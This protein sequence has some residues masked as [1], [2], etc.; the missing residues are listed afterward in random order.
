MANAALKT[1]S[2][3]AFTTTYTPRGT[4][5]EVTLPGINAFS[6]D[7]LGLPAN[8]TA[9]KAPETEHQ[10]VFRLIDERRIEEA[11]HVAK[12]LID[13]GAVEG[14]FI[15]GGTP[16]YRRANI[17]VTDKVLMSRKGAFSD[18]LQITPEVAQRILQHNPENRKIVKAGLVDRIRDIIEGRYELNG[19]T[20]ILTRQGELNDGQHRLWATLL[21]GSTI[22]T[23]VFFGAERD[24]RLTIDTGKVR[25]GETRFSFLGIPNA[26][27]AEALVRLA[28]RVD[29]N[30]EATATE[31]VDTYLLDSAGAGHYQAA[32]KVV[33][34]QPK[35]APRAAMCVAAFMLLRAGAPLGQVEKFFF[36]VRTAGAGGKKSPSVSL[37]EGIIGGIFK[38]PQE[39]LVYTTANLYGEWRRGKKRTF[40]IVTVLPEL[41]TF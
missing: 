35:G 9:V 21:C 39:H 12:R 7:I 6:G 8:D 1:A 4:K 32:I 22:R 20:I 10:K 16:A 33:G 5:K 15:Y 28:H 31:K 41:V 18:I 29:H 34:T 2:E 37:R 26:A 40:E 24:T 17:M 23:N 25:T 38:G 11:A 13:A 14:F 3:H 27:L 19:Q 36:E 30:R